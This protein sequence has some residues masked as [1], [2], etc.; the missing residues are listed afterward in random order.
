MTAAFWAHRPLPSRVAIASDEALDSFLERLA[1]ANDLEPAHI[2]RALRHGEGGRDATLAFFMTA[3][4]IEVL[5]RI[6]HLSGIPIER[7]RNATLL[8]FDGGLPLYLDGLDPL[9]RHTYRNVVA[10]GW[11]PRFGSQVCCSCLAQTGI[12][13]A[14]WRLPIVAVC[15]QHGTCFTTQCAGCNQRFRSH[16]YSPLRSI[17]GPEQPC[18]NPVG[19]RKPCLHSVLAHSSEGAEA[20]TLECAKNVH[21]A[22]NGQPTDVLGDPVDA[23]AYLAELRN[24][25]TLLLHLGSRPSAESV[26]PWAGELR[27][28]ARARSTRVRGARWGYSPP[29]S[30]EVRGAV[31]GSAHEILAQPA[32]ASGGERLR[33]WLEYIRDERNGPSAWLVNRTKRTPVMERLIAAAASNRRDVGRRLDGNL[34]DHHLRPSAIPQLMDVAIYRELFAGMLGGYEWTGRLYVSLCAVRAIV[35]VPNWSDAAARIG[36]PP[37]VGARASRAARSRML[38]TPEEL[39]REIKKALASIPLERDFRALEARVRALA[40]DADDWHVGWRASMSPAR[41]AATLQYAVTWMWCEVAQGC[42]DTSP[43]WAAGPARGVKAGYRAFRDRLPP[44]AQDS[45]RQLV[46]QGLP[47]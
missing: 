4:H 37:E 31:L 15:L 42:L 30:A 25:A 18:G 3:P 10:Q 2:L 13:R 6:A 40:S 45:L 20:H 17:L 44:E 7:L 24:L 33:E 21:R 11:F 47:R 29:L 34:H 35:S 26:V 32:L 38:A 39:E 5:T 12:W 23:R 16:R 41:R 14:H 22:L 19:L 1:D 36:L 28:E 46:L 8:R 27:E 9:D 43:A